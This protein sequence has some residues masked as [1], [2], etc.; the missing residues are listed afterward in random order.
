MSYMKQP[1][2][3]GTKEHYFQVVN[4][5]TDLMNKVANEHPDTTDLLK[6]LFLG[7][8]IVNNE[9]VLPSHPYFKTT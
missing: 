2:K 5:M 4:H 9:Y 3:K 8:Q 6:E 7:L 1:P